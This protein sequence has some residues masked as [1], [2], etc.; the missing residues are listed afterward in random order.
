MIYSG[1]LYSERLSSWPLFPE[2]NRIYSVVKIL[3]KHVGKGMFMKQNIILLL[4]MEVYN[5][6]RN[7][8]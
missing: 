4:N 1:K 2:Q 8:I 7:H 3:E 5:V 6:S